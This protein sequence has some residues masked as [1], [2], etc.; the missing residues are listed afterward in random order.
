MGNQLQ[1]LNAVQTENLQ[2]AHQYVPWITVNDEHT[3]DMQDAAENNLIALICKT[4][5]VGSNTN[6]CRINTRLIVV[7]TCRR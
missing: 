5:T 2:P 3:E 4:Y 6:C 7:H 1:H